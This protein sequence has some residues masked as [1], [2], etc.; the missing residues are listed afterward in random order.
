MVLSGSDVIDEF[1]E[2]VPY[3]FMGRRL[4][5][6]VRLGWRCVRRRDLAESTLQISESRADFSTAPVGSKRE[7]RET[8]ESMFSNELA[9][10]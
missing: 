5:N 4:F 2:L 1:R 8:F 6:G 3:R 10:R 7:E 9:S